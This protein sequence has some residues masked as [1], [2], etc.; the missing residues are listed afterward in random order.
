MLVTTIVTFGLAL[1]MSLR[2]E[3]MRVGPAIAMFII[4][5]VAEIG[6]AHV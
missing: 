2:I 6:R 1:T 4:F 3:K 5:A